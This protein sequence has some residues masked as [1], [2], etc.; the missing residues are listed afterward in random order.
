M[1]EILRIPVHQDEI[2]LGV[3]NAHRL[4]NVLDRLMGAERT[5]QGYTARL[6]CQ[7]V[8]ESA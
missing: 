5:A 1:S 8:V 6:G 7:E 2:D 4:Q 3:R